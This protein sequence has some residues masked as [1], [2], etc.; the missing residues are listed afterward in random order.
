MSQTW[1]NLLELMGQHSMV[2]YPK[3][4][5]GI[6]TKDLDYIPCKNLSQSPKS[7]FILDPAKYL[8]Y[9]DQILAIYHSHPGSSDPFPSSNDMIN[10]IL[11]EYKFIVGFNNQFYIYWLDNTSIVFEKLNENHFNT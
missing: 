8:E 6:I 11:S 10:S 3:E 2:E 7:S 9:E 1:N 4:C 5:C